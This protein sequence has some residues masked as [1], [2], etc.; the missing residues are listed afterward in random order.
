MNKKQLLF[1]LIFLSVGNVTLFAQEW[2]VAAKVS[3]LGGNMEL[4]RSFGDYF[5][6]H[7][8]ANYFTLNQDLEDDSDY[9]AEVSAGLMSFSALGDYYP[10]QSS[11][12]RL[13]LGAYFNLNE[14]DAILTPV[15]SYDVG[16]DVYTPEELGTLDA[17]IK[18]NPI[19]PYIGLGFGNPTSGESGFGFSFDI[20][21]MYQGGS[22]VDLTA[23]GLLEPSAEEDQVT[24]IQ[25]NL[26]WFKWYPVVSLGLSYKF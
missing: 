22:I 9:S 8:G 24:L 25:D 21:S 2:A 26:N 7:F 11:T 3:T 19:A 16:G 1:L 17:N 6:L 4:Y 5:N 23:E 18:F 10:F 14:V 20:G 12:F 13:T 15:N